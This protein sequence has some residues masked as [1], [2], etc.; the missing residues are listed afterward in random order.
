MIK[1]ILIVFDADETIWTSKHHDYVSSIPSD[2]KRIGTD[3]ALR[4]ADRTA[5]QLRKG[6]RTYLKDLSR[7]KHITLGL[8]SDNILSVVVEVLD[9]FRLLHFFHREAFNVRLWKGHCFKERMIQ[10]MLQRP[11][12]RKKTLS[13]LYWFDDADYVQE[14]SQLG[15]CFFHIGS[16]K[17]LRRGIYDILK[18]YGS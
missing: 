12:W 17:A 9:C 16:D 3:V 8:V 5:F 1:N 10:E 4:S 6:V 15:A 2:W 14:A 7:N 13:K 18:S 11:Y